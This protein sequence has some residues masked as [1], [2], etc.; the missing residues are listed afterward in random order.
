[1]ALGLP[2][3]STNVGGIPYLIENG[4]DGLLIEPEDSKTMAEKISMLIEEKN[5]AKSIIKNARRKVE[6][7]NWLIVKKRWVKTI[8]TCKKINTKAKTCPKN[9]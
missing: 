1:M 7:F 5:I 6:D 3:V 2:V 4:V 8:S 9:Y